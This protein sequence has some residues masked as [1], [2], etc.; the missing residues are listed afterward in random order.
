[1]ESDFSF[2]ESGRLTS[3]KVTQFHVYWLS[4]CRG[5]ILPSRGAIDLS[6]IPALQPYLLFVDLE[7]DAPRVRYRLVGTQIV[8]A[9]GSDFTGQY[10]EDCGFSIEA[11]LRDCYRRLIAGRRAI[12]ATYNWSTVAL[13]GIPAT[14]GVSQSGFFPLSSDGVVID[15]AVSIEDSNI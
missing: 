5:G 15:G 4:K 11:H 6:E 13:P 7:G 2:I 10:L 12:F 1:M 9:H 8:M 14:S 3:R